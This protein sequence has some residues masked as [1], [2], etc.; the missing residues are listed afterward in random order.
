ME[1]AEKVRER[2]ILIDVVGIED[3]K[4]QGDISVLAIQFTTSQSA[5]LDRLQMSLAYVEGSDERQKI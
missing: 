4:R 3:A 1:L 5:Q 2:M